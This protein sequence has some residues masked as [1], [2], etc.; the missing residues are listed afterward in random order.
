MLPRRVSEVLP[1]LVLT[2]SL[3]F[4][5]AGRAHGD[6]TQTGVVS[7]TVVDSQEQPL[8]DVEVRLSGPQTQRRVLT[9]DQGRF[10]FPAL[11]VGTYS[12]TAELLGLV[13]SQN[14]V[15]VYI[16]KTVEVKLE[17]RE[18]IGEPTP[19]SATQDLIHV[20]AFAPLIDRFDTKV[21]ASVSRDFL[22]ALPVA[23][24]YQ[25]VALLLP[26]VAGGEDGNPNVSGALR[27]SNLFLIDGVDTTDPTTGLFGLNL[28]FEAIQDVDVTVA[29]PSV[30]FGRSSGAVINVVTRAGNNDFRGTARWL[31]THNSWG[32]EYVVEDEN[33]RPEAAAATASDHLDSTI[34]A[35]LAGPLVT[36]RLWF[37]G[38]FEH[39]A[40]SFFRPSLEGS[41]WDEDTQLQDSAA[42]LT[43]QINERHSLVGQL[44][45]DSASFAF[46][47]P[48]DQS[49]GEN[50]A[51]RPPRQLRDS[52]LAFLP[53]DVFALQK[54]S[55][56][57]NFAKLQWN[58]ALG[59]NLSLAATAAAQDRRLERNL[60]S[61][62]DLTS[63]APHLAAEPYDLS[64]VPDL[65]SFFPSL[66]LYN[67]TSD[68][69]FEERRRDQ[70]NL[71][72]NALLRHGKVDHDVR[73]GFD[74]QQTRSRQR[75]LPSGHRGVDPATGRTVEGQL[76]LDQDFRFSCLEEGLCMDF[77]AASGEFQPYLFFN[78]WQREARQTDVETV[79]FYANDALSLGR[80]LLSVGA[81]FESVRGRGGDGSR[82][83][84]DTSIA[85][86]LAIKYDP[87]GDGQVLLSVTYSRFSEP[88]SQQFL[89]NFVR[90]ELFSGFSLYHWGELDGLDCSAADPSNLAS[91]CWL[92]ADQQPLFPV[93]GA[94]PNLA[95][96]RTSVS[97][98]VF[99]YERQLT[100][101]TALRLSFVDRR[102]RDLWDDV[103]RGAVDPSSPSPDEFE[104]S[105]ENLPEAKRSYRALQ[106]L[107]QKRFA[108]RWQLL[109]SY[110]WSQA[111]GNLF[112]NNGFSSF[113][114]FTDQSDTN[115]VN[116]F[117]P[118]PYDR[119]NQLKLFANYRRAWTKVDL[120]LG[121]VAR[122]ESGIP[123]Q[124]EQDTFPF[125]TRFLTPR[126]SQRLEDFW[127]V[128]LSASVG[129]PVLRGV[130]LDLKLEVFNLTDEQNPI[131]VETQVDFGRFG[132]PRSID[133][134]QAPR[135]I[136]L[137]L[138]LRF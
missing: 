135:N 37:Y 133:D 67:G 120:S 75:L 82:L 131:G 41:R 59:Q 86:R 122:F 51:S 102:W 104:V 21:G 25:S 103:L 130:D 22:D 124:Q 6:G 100:P 114:D 14:D 77:D 69:G 50:R 7:G 80:W 47:A 70:G 121:T 55:Q 26:G 136:R 65:A 108:D 72:V 43:W 49:P 83:I 12:V 81:R 91:D 24:F 127:Q 9:D 62:R 92:L 78:F 15:R 89:D 132:R 64:V 17:L 95:L 79:A 76:F 98:L 134:L 106:L 2:L 38:A 31:L 97:E 66:A 40:D 118:A 57:G 109:A 119:P 13:A 46:Y 115:A 42:K 23:R 61:R 32:E 27:G 112:E 99:S 35:T 60:L 111:E 90:D 29:A 30:E 19:Q 1:C 110:T 96:E 84:D 123:F 45:A 129:S 48:F 125:G 3:C 56:D 93:Q 39:V 54:R 116:R 138:G 85:P 73:F 4:L 63:G 33:L 113:A 58:T 71:V 20:L 87:K 137:T 36:D 117:G 74:F 53:G 28:N 16:D 68:E 5:C 107:I 52:F 126:G 10:R 128:D 88:F 8:P 101:R 34:T 94:S 105:L 44:T 11:E 18:T